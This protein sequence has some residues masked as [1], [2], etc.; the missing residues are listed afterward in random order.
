MITIE[1]TPVA[2]DVAAVGTQLDAAFATLKQ[3][4]ADNEPV[5]V[6]VSDADLLGQG[7][8]CDAAVAA[9]LLGMVRTVAIEGAKQG[10]RVNCVTHRDGASS[11]AAT[12]E[13]IAAIE[14][15][16]GQLVRP[17]VK[18]LGKAPV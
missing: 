11:V 1:Q 16:S 3:A 15:L 4:V 17:G 13:G 7:D 18:H 8:P 5:T 6:V 9:A 12:A 14:G 10:F 2:G